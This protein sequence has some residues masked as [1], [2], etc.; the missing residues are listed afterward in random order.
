M[1]SLQ[2]WNRN[3]RKHFAKLPWS[4]QNYW[5]MCRWK[6]LLMRHKMLKQTA[7]FIFKIEEKLQKF[8]LP[9]VSSFTRSESH[10]WPGNRPLTRYVKLRL[11]HEPGM[12]GRFP[13][14]WLQRKPLV[15]DPGMHHGKCATHVPWCM[16]GLLTRCGGEN[17]PGI[18]GIC[19]TRNFTYIFGWFLKIQLN[20]RIPNAVHSRCVTTSLTTDTACRSILCFIP[21]CT[22]LYLFVTHNSCSLAEVLSFNLSPTSDKMYLIFAFRRYH[23]DDIKWKHFSRY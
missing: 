9:R 10:G 1:Q 17:V 19:A 12:P 14:H 7:D 4:D 20:H 15:N 3:P 6:Y 21:I 22:P 13:R 11:A 2:E 23:D 16:P 5:N 8:E 18:P